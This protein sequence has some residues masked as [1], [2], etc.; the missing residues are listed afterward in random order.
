MLSISVLPACCLYQLTAP[1]EYIVLSGGIEVRYSIPK[2]H[3]APNGHVIQIVSAGNEH[4][5]ITETPTV[6][7]EGYLAFR[8]G[9]V[10]HA[11][12]FTF[13]L[14]DPARILV[15]KTD[16]MVAKWPETSIKLPETAV[17]LTSNVYMDVNV[18]GVQCESLHPDVRYLLQV[19]YKG[20]NDTQGNPKDKS[21]SIVMFKRDYTTIQSLSDLKLRIG[22][23][24]VDQAGLYSAEL[25]R[26]RNPRILL[27][28]SNPMFVHWS[29]KYKLQSDAQ[30][31]FPCSDTITI[32]VTQAKCSGSMDKVRLY[33][34]VLKTT[35]SIASPIDLIY[36][37][38]KPVIPHSLS[39][40]SSLVTFN[41]HDFDQDIAGYCFSYF[42]MAKTGAV[43]EQYS[44]CLPTHPSSGKKILFT[45]EC[46]CH[47]L[48]YV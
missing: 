5:I 20:F 4:I 19:S 17:A 8:C 32:E 45:R 46:H 39:S 36:V 1:R 47:G 11:G 33:S 26:S 30:S 12:N 3:S 44:L 43:T 10:D 6:S 34:Q 24:E 15:A 9:V 31:I 42:S 7:N 29:D 16:T 38:E 21:A 14:L 41:C 37:K 23:E 18:T 35:S 40:M 27:G 25:Y 22:C 2:N 48:I 28:K 13:K